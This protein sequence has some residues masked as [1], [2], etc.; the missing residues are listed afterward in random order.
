MLG[1]PIIPLLIMSSLI[2]LTVFFGLK[3]YGLY[4]LIV[5]LIL[6]LILFILR[7]KCMDDSRALSFLVWDFKGLLYRLR[8]GSSVVSFTSTVSNEKRRKEHVC[9]WFKDNTTSR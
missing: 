2:L 7:I 3:F 9:D 8:S 5:P 6:I 1:L 4:S